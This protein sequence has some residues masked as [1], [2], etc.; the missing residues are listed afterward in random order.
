MAIEIVNSLSM[1]SSIVNEIVNE[2]V[3]DFDFF[4]KMHSSHRQLINFCYS[5]TDG[6]FPNAKHTVNLASLL[7]NMR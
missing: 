1:K 5:Y 6:D 2:I 3:N 4:I 7:T